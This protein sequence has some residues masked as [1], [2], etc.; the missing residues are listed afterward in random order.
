M[1]EIHKTILEA[2]NLQQSIGLQD[3][4]VP[5]LV[6]KTSSGK[7]Y[8]IQNNLSTALSLPVVKIL[9][10]NEQP[11]EILGYPKFMGQDKLEFLK[12]A[13]WTDKPSIFFFDE[14]DKSREE[15][16]ASILTLMREGTIRGRHLPKGSVIIAAMNET[17]YLSDPLKARC[18]FLPFNH[19]RRHLADSSLEQAAEYL[20]SNTLPPV[21]PDQVS[22][23]ENLH[24][25]SKFQSFNPNLL[26]DKNKVKTLLSGLYPDR[27]LLPMLNILC[28]LDDIHYHK[29][30]DNEKLYNNFLNSITNVHDGHKHFIELL[31][32]AS[33]DY[34]HVNMIM[35]LIRKFSASNTENLVK[36]YEL[37]HDAWLN[38]V[39][40]I[41][42]HVFSDKVVKAMAVRMHEML[43]ELTS[44][45]DNKLHDLDYKFNTSEKEIKDGNTEEIQGGS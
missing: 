44:D 22:I 15:L 43:S 30:L 24:Y 8:W 41:G 28:G 13:W 18:L 33:H 32:V 6:G 12:P 45:I 27:D 14:L 9:L 5:V 42:N 38:D 16:H 1:H 4:K 35:Q 11:D 23:P 29:L 20:Q 39:P 34:E 40:N 2:C 10:Q 31:K 21:L 17:E 3:T 37:C 36:F 19:T 7:T 26:Q 25:I